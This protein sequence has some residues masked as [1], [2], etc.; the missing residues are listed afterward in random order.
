ME[1]GCE[2]HA[3]YTKNV[4]LVF[5]C[6]TDTCPDCAIY[7]P[8]KFEYQQ[9]K[10]LKKIML[11]KCKMENGNWKLEYR[12]WKIENYSTRIYNVSKEE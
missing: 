4:D 6:N 5:I 2:S 10:Y 12:K 8:W 9:L 3:L 7:S 1:V 11:G